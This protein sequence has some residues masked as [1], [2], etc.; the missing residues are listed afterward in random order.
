V[1][2]QFGAVVIINSVVLSTD[3]NG[4][5]IATAASG[6]NAGKSGSLTAGQWS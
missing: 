1:N 2:V 5:L 4:D 6:L 3:G